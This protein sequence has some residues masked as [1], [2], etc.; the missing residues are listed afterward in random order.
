MFTGK[1]PSAICRPTGRSDH[2]FGSCTRFVPR[3][4][5]R[6]GSARWVLAG[7]GWWAQPAKDAITANR[8]NKRIDLMC[9][10]GCSSK[11]GLFFARRAEKESER[12]CGDDG[13]YTRQ[14]EEALEIH[15][16]A[17]QESFADQFRTE[18]I[19]DQRA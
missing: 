18:D 7:W 12:D 3:A 13:R 1:S 16:A 15:N 11:S 4:P 6:S 19:G 10:E 9:G 8:M 17:F 14:Q 2:M 5:G